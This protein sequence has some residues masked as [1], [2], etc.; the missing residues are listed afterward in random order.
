L[1]GARTF[2]P[3]SDDE[4]LRI[5]HDAVDGR[6]PPA[7][8]GVQVVGQPAGPVAGILAFTAHH[9]V[10]ADVDP[11]WVRERVPPGDLSAPVGPA[12]VGE[13]SA[14]LGVEAGSLDVVFAGRGTGLGPGELLAAPPDPEHPR[15]SRSARYRT[16]VEMFR[17]T[18]G[19]GVLIVGRGLAGRWEAAYEV[20]EDARGRGLGRTLAAAALDLVP[21]GE[22]LFVSVAPGNVASLRAVLATGRYR[23]IAGEVLFA[24]G[25][26]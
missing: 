21:A 7:D 20:D 14:A 1:A 5:L 15:V 8:G 19:D 23:P 4:I 25:G 11:S 24:V 12:F 10:A 22:P 17:T 2:G 9:V 18:D 26:A 6:P 3:V 13:L 16:D